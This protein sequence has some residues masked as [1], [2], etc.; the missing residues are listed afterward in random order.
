MLQR[1][2]KYFQLL[3]KGKQINISLDRLKPAY[4]L[5]PFDNKIQS[6]TSKT[7]HTSV[8]VSNQTSQPTVIHHTVP[9]EQLE[10]TC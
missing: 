7:D 3:I 6:P 5:Q 9:S 10:R 8:P 4:M 1:T 2:P